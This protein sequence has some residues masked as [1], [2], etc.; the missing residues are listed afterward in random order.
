MRPLKL[1]FYGL[2]SFKEEQEIDFSSLGA[3]HV[4]GIFGPTGSGKSTI[5]DAIT[6][7]LYGKVER[8]PDKVR[9]IINKS[10][11][12][13]GAR[14]DFSI[15]SGPLY[16]VYRVER[17]YVS[18]ED[19]ISCRM[20][21]LCELS[22]LGN[23]VLA[24]KSTLVDGQVEAILGLTVDD[25]TRAVVLPQGR[26]AEFLG[27]KG[28]ER[29][30]MLGR[31]FNLS[32]YGEKLYSLASNRAKEVEARVMNMQS[33]QQGLGNASREALGVAEAEVSVAKTSL[34]TALEAVVASSK[35]WA[36]A[37]VIR[38]LQDKIRHA[39]ERQA[40]LDAES[41][42]LAALQA[43][44]D[45][46]AAAEVLWPSAL[47][48]DES[49]VT[50]EAALERQSAVVATL[51]EA[52]AQE[53]SSLIALSAAKTARQRDEPRI[54]M[55]QH[56]LKRAVVLTEERR[57]LTAALATER[58]ALSAA[59]TR[60]EMAKQELASILQREKRAQESQ[61]VLRQEIAGTEVLP[62][63]R[64]AL[65]LALR[66][67]AAWLTLASQ[68]GERR[69]EEHSRS[70]SLETAKATLSQARQNVSSLE[71][72]H[73]LAK[74]SLD[75]VLSRHLPEVGMS[76]HEAHN[77][78]RLSLQDLKYKAA[79]VGRIIDKQETL[80]LSKSATE[81]QLL[82]MQETASRAE[83]RVDFLRNLV[84]ENEAKYKAAKDACLI[85]EL[86]AQVSPGEKCPVCGSRSH[87]ELGT[88]LPPAN[89]EHFAAA[90]MEST[91]LLQK[92]IA[93]Q[94][95]IAARAE[96]L[97]VGLADILRQ[98]EVLT[99][100]RLALLKDMAGIKSSFPAVWNAL[101]LP[102]IEQNIALLAKDIENRSEERRLWQGALDKGRQAERVLADKLA[103]GREAQA[104]AEQ[105]V[106]GL[107]TEFTCLVAKV[108]TIA[109]EEA[110]AKDALQNILKQHQISDLKEQRELLQGKDRKQKELSDTMKQLE[111][112]LFELVALRQNGEQVMAST[113]EGAAA[114]LISL[115]GL[116]ERESMLAKE[117]VSLVGD[118]DPLVEA[119]V[120]EASLV[121]LREEETQSEDNHALVV[122]VVAQAKNDLASATEALRLADQALDKARLRF[123]EAM[124]GSPFVTRSDLHQAREALGSREAWMA[125]I[126][127]HREQRMLLAN[128][129]D[130]WREALAGR[131]VS[132]AAW[133]IARHT[134]LQAEAT[135]DEAMRQLGQA[136]AKLA[137]IKTRHARYMNLAELIEAQ[138]KER[139]LTME[140][141]SLLRGNAL[142]EFMA[143]EHLQA[144]TATATEWLRTLSSHRYALE[145]APDGGFLIRDD[146]Q[147]GLRR[148][149]HTLSGGETFITSLALALALSMQIQL[150]G[151][152]PLEFFFL[153]EG[154]GTLDA[155]LLETVMCCLERMQGQ[156][157]SIGIISHVREL[158][159]RI[160]RKIIVTPAQLG[161]RG[162]QVQ[163]I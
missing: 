149:V 93:E 124:Q 5:I 157:L 25:F 65:E 59:E 135:R 130:A 69:K 22:S 108:M 134:Y 107:E 151:R 23:K 117:L 32:G 156:N 145:V 126:N 91:T 19:S 115:R 92:A 14:F 109:N 146:G 162:S 103:R 148:P 50:Q 141:V 13:A 129:L 114:L 87:P 52:V 45:R 21:R 57:G 30:E 33:E 56:E 104:V 26:F 131:A 36:E 24:D 75:E 113:Q 80:N 128:D 143:G 155:E 121:A 1:S 158:V 163:V 18:K 139:D 68:L 67:E 82:A 77:N 102:E 51:E 28:K 43:K 100:E 44:L 116:T 76:E 72:E 35:A 9:G 42:R 2:N 152:F 150:R 11:T 66:T 88:R 153:D 49:T 46:L 122:S 12:E 161:G 97:H 64:V 120:A 106:A 3:G 7:A 132:E 6:L 111:A 144:V 81:T 160:P 73:A 96:A 58:L 85:G 54:L 86:A 159:E 154:F 98:I 61:V 127:L 34:A 101:S 123:A 99:A 17:K 78:Y 62:E 94:G 140:L 47:A 63:E 138:A 10:L 71:Q 40:A 137:D 105:H 48:L 16:K 41:S 15:G 38:E 136:E 119:A 8:A 39:L 37:Q 79:E 74:A 4:F 118:A 110:L 142:V 147:G 70:G 89:L 55:R 60:L 112:K 53:A 31:I 133:E 20:A 95:A 125:E 29:R 90:T 84:A 27:L 83:E